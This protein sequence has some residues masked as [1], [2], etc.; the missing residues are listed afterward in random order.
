LSQIAGLAVKRQTGGSSPAVVSG[1]YNPRDVSSVRRF[2]TAETNRLNKAHWQFADDQSINTWLRDYLTTIRGRAHYETRHNPILTGIVGTHADDIVGQDGPSLQVQSD[3]EAY[4]SA[5]E[6]VWREW[7]KAPTF[8]RTISG[9][10]MLK[11][12][13]RSLWRSGEFLTTIETDRNATGPVQMRLKLRHPRQLGTPVDLAGDPSIDMGIR[14]DANDVPATYY[15]AS[16]RATVNDP[17]AAMKSA[18]Y[19]ADL[20][21]HEFLMDEEDQIR[22]VPLA[23]PSLN[24]SADLRDYNTQVQDA[25]RQMADQACLMYTD[26]PDADLHEENET[27]EWKRRTIPMLPPGWKPYSHAANQPPAQY[28]MYLAER[29][30]EMGRPVGMPLLMVRLDASRHNYSSARLDTQVYRR[31]VAGLQTWI[32][33]SDRSYGTLNRLADVIAT[34]ARFA[35]PELR[36]RPAKVFYLWTWPVMPHVDPTKESKAEADTLASATES[37][38]RALAA[39]GYDLQTHVATLKRERQILADAEISPPWLSGPAPAPPV[40]DATAEAIEETV[41]ETVEENA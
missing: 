36:N 12:W 29:M 7:F 18:P 6:D 39:R 34:E 2:E 27:L 40:D 9:A 21:V 5:L 20:V 14:F 4:N 8:R 41:E 33:G 17:L 15:L 32:S 16:S 13:I 1:W 25:A 22:G 10:R 37:Y 30:R 3:N 28:E 38:T 24:T 19:P 11:L 35:V 26:S 23:N 31:S